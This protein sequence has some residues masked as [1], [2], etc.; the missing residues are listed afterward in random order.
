[1]AGSLNRDTGPALGGLRPLGPGLDV[2]DVELWAKPTG[3][4]N[5][6][7]ITQVSPQAAV[8]MSNFRLNRGTLIQRPGVALI[9]GSDSTTVMNVIDFVTSDSASHYIRF[10]TD[11]LDRYDTSTDS[12]IPIS[13]PTLTGDESNQFTYTGWNDMLV[14]SNGKDGTFQLQ[15]GPAYSYAIIAG[16]PAAFHLTT[17]AGR[18]LAT[19]VFDPTYVPNRIR[20]STK[21]DNTDWTDLGSGFEDLRSTPGGVIDEAFGVYPI[22]DQMAFVVRQNS[23]WVMYETGQVDAPF[24]FS[25]LFDKLPCASRYAIVAVPGGV[26]LLTNE[27]VLMVTL[28]GPQVIG[29][30]IRQHLI[31]FLQSPELAYASFDIRRQ[32]Y[33]LGIKE[34]GSSGSWLSAIYRYNLFDHGWSRD[35]YPF[36]VKSL[37]FTRYKHD[38]IQVASL[39]GT[40]AALAGTVGNLGATS[41]DGGMLMV[42]HDSTTGKD[43]VVREDATQFEDNLPMGPVSGLSTIVSGA[44][45]AG[46]PFYNTEL[47]E[48]QA[49]YEADVQAFIALSVSTNSGL[50]LNPFGSIN[51]P[52]TVDG[53]GGSHPNVVALSKTVSPGPIVQLVFQV[54]NLCNFRLIEALARIQLG[55]RIA[56]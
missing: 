44:L 51:A 25:R 24:Q 32:E 42:C 18:I 40:V 10:R 22:T 19:S 38:D 49:L 55:G 36:Q 5:Q 50:A 7:A 46:G 16:A 20:W 1:M 37:C 56:I 15:L 47:I 8:V 52:T 3:I 45:Q 14:F 41:S 29:A 43:F 48:V 27:D 9:G 4:D 12:W 35:D 13:G 11:G 33:V 54:Q 31:D 53:L 34:W 6:N 30:P 28:Q 17:F 39:P 21:D 23:I 26:M 2:Q